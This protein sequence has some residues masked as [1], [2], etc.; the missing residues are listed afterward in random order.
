MY[1]ES[2]TSKV[3]AVTEDAEMGTCKAKKHEFPNSWT[4]V[5]GVIVVH[6]RGEGKNSLYGGTYTELS[7]MVHW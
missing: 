6:E 1:E 3:D 7:R 2:G 5:G 4:T